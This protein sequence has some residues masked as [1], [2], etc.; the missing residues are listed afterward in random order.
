MS[1]SGPQPRRFTPLSATECITRLR[2][3]TIGRVG[4]NT[5]DGPQILPV[6]YVFRDGQIIFRTAP[7]GALSELRN[8]RQVAF[9]VDEIDVVTRTGWSVLVRGWAKAATNPDELAE[10]WQEPEPSP[11][12]GGN[13]TLFI[14]ISPEQFS[15]REISG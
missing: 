10:L 2:S 15:G 4:W 6:T 5:V 8:V 13:R 9:E 3:H 14:T 7:Y 12:A 11:W 1:T